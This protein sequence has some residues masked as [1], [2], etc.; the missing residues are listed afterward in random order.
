MLGVGGGKTEAALVSIVTAT[1][2]E[3]SAALDKDDIVV[4]PPLTTAEVVGLLTSETVKTKRVSVVVKILDGEFKGKVYGFSSA[5][6][7]RGRKH[8]PKF[9]PTNNASTPFLIP[10]RARGTGR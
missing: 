6:V 4:V 8:P 7:L 1:N 2:E 10:A 3:L 9:V 5:Y